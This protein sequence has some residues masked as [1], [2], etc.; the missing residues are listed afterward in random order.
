MSQK[1]KTATNDF[2]FR[3]KDDLNGQKVKEFLDNQAPHKSQ[4]I[5]LAILLAINAF[6]QG[7]LL[8]SLESWLLNK[9]INVYSQEIIPN[10]NSILDKTDNTPEERKVKKE[11]DT[12]PKVAK[13]AT[14]VKQ[15]KEKNI[16]EKK[17]K[18]RNAENEKSSS[19]RLTN[20]EIN[21]M[22]WDG[23]SSDL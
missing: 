23:N 8:A 19:G 1:K 9:K 11:K 12:K 22:L 16:H 13:K 14:N 5:E 4:S 7:D 3:Y 15:Q 2:H 6:G 17:V 10:K 20:E 18:P 21:K